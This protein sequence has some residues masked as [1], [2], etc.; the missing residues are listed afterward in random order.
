MAAGWLPTWLISRLTGISVDVLR[1]WHRNGTLPASAR[2]G[3]RGVSHIYN[4]HDYEKARL[5]A[6][7]L[8]RCVDERKLREVLV[9]CCGGSRSEELDRALISSRLKAV[10]PI[11]EIKQIWRELDAEYPLSRLNEFADE[12][13]MDPRI[14][15]GEPRLKGH[16]ITTELVRVLARAAL[17]D[18]DR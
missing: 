9:E 5:A 10:L 3:R 1:R 13:D 2:A 8:D 4:W 16:R 15:S 17:P 11:A 7:L 12:I 18:R 14:K 6:K